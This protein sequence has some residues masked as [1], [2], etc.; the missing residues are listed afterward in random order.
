MSAAADEEGIK[1]VSMF[2]NDELANE[3]W[4]NA[5]RHVLE[6]LNGLTDHGKNRGVGLQLDGILNVLDG[7][8][9]EVSWRRR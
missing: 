2:L 6:M 9:R 3:H 4:R 8:A 7:L 5:R 1:K